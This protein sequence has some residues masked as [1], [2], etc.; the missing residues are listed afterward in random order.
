ML[1]NHL[2]S[3]Y[4]EQAEYAKALK[5]YTEEGLTIERKILSARKIPFCDSPLQ[6]RYG[7]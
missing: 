5:V 6:S 3:F 2:G 7:A 4:F 1:L